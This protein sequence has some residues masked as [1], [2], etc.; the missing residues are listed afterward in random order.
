MYSVLLGEIVD[1]KGS[2]LDSESV[3]RGFLL[4]SQ[5]HAVDGS[6]ARVKVSDR[7]VG[8]DRDIGH[9]FCTRILTSQPGTTQ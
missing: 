6:E 8:Q 9:A 3:G 2:G 5:P 7:V 1:Y 4:V